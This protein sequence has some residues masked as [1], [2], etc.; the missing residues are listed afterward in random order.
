M[1]NGNIVV[2]AFRPFFS[3]IG[4]KSGIPM[5][6]KLCG[7]EQGITQITRTV[8]FQFREKNVDKA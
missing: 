1:E 4:S 6:D 8:F 3:K 7:V 5:T 2:F